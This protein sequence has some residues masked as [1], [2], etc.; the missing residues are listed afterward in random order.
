LTNL[1]VW[2]RASLI[3]IA[4]Q[5]WKLEHGW[6]P[7]RLEQL[8]GTHLDALPRDPWSGSDFGYRPQGFPNAILFLG[9]I[10]DAGQPLLW[11][12]G[13]LDGR[14]EAVENKAGETVFVA[15]SENGLAHSLDQPP[16]SWGVCI[17]FV[18]W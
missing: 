13:A 4:L 3:T 14:I 2:R 8:V 18:L 7:D 1:E 15:L 12:V 5:A 17:P 11:S 16:M 10:V 6:L 9:Q